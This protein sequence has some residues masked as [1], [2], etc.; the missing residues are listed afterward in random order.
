MSEKLTKLEQLPP[1]FK[2]SK[3][4]AAKDFEV[5]DWF[6]NLYM[7]YMLFYSL[8]EF[9][10]TRDDGCSRFFIE[11]IRTI[12]DQI[13][14]NPFDTDV[15]VYREFGPFDLDVSESGSTWYTT[16]LD[17][18]EVLAAGELIREDQEIIDARKEL[19]SMFNTVNS[20]W[21][22]PPILFSRLFRIYLI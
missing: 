18:S 6:R 15:A 5:N 1:T 22:T 13:L 16:L 17:I 7:R 3:Y 10:T 8:A 9:F 11:K 14:E 20:D 2:N 19:E 12:V 21:E 4:L